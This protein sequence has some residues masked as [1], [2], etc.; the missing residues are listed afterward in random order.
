MPAFLFRLICVIVVLLVAAGLAFWLLV[1]REKLQKKEMIRTLP[2]VLCVPAV[3]GSSAMTVEAF[4]TVTA[5][6]SVKLAMEIAGRID[7]IH[8]DFREGGTIG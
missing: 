6:N 2:K 4:G 3:S 5:R 1:P 7:Y 8:P